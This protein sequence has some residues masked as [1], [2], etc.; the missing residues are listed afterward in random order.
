[1]L[2]DACIM[3]PELENIVRLIEDPRYKV[4]SFDLFDTLIRRKVAAPEHVFWRVGRQ[5]ANLAGNTGLT[6]KFYRAR[7]LA[8]HLAQERARQQGR[9]DTNLPE[10]Y[11]TLASVL[12]EA[13][14]YVDEL[15]AIEV[16]EERRAL[17]IYPFGARLFQAARNSGKRIIISSDQYLPVAFLEERLQAFGYEGYEKLLLSGHIGLLKT[18]GS[19]YEWMPMR[20]G[21]DRHQILHVGDNAYVDKKVADRK[22]VRGVLLPRS[23]RLAGHFGADS[24]ASVHP[25]LGSYAVA[26]YL[27]ALADAVTTGQELP[28]HDEIDYVGYVFYGPLM[29]YLSA[30]L[31]ERLRHGEIDRLWLLARDAEGISKAMA[32]LYPEHSDRISYVYASRR[33]LVYP[34]GAVSSV[35]IFRHYESLARSDKTIDEFL[36]E[37]SSDGADFTSVAQHFHRCDRVADLS[38][39]PEL[40]RRLDSRCAE[41]RK[42]KNSEVRNNLLRYYSTFAGHAQRIGLFDLGW[43]GN[44]Q[45]ALE[46]IF[47]EKD[48]KFCGYYIGQI[49][50]GGLYKSSIESENF[51]FSFNFP[52]DAFEDVS[53]NI[54]PLELIF[55]GTELSTV[56]VKETAGKWSAVFENDTPQKAAT[57]EVCGRLQDAAIRFIRDTVMPDP[58][59]RQ[60]S[61]S[62]EEG[63]ALMREFL[64]RPGRCDA[65][66]LAALSWE[67]NIGGEG[68]PLIAKTER[69]GGRAISRAR[70]ASSWPAGFDAM[71]TPR[72][73]RKMRRYWSRRE[74]TRR[75]AHK[76]RNFIRGRRY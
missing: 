30:W 16:S 44:L 61:S 62:R 55:G 70:A 67:M 18:T 46:Q 7:L 27:N 57:R 29:C 49:F 38:L 43:R 60:M 12:P 23:D 34:T 47:S 65:K 45:R 66:A 74:K 53:K 41:L 36:R 4:I 15:A 31:A 1:M 9:E 11:D 52:P 3:N 72:A 71:Q 73:L 22:G 5:F 50:E 32:L 48:V 69:T 58:Y 25:S 28:P 37:I 2:N 24:A 26:A 17:E 56:A 54:C 39:R 59:L 19:L 64:A 20:F 35:E 75:L 76:I 8:G 10:I 6:S 40:E 21:I 14:K 51:A 42:D 13:R 68:K 63:V 33:M